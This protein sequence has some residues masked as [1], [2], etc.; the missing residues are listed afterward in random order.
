MTRWTKIAIVALTGLVLGAGVAIAHEQQQPYP[1]GGGGEPEP[2]GDAPSKAKLT[3]NKNYLSAVM[4]G[5]WE[6]GE[7]STGRGSAAIHVIDESTICYGMTVKGLADGDAPAAAHIHKGKINQNGPIVLEFEN[8]PEEGNPGWGGG[9]AQADPAVIRR[10]QRAPVKYYVNIHSDQFKDGA[11]RGQL[12][13]TR[14][15]EPAR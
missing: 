10:I 11:L 6:L 3:W 7:K 4:D 8:V 13:W 9:C 12:A 2:S 1:G 15:F 14:W 5:K